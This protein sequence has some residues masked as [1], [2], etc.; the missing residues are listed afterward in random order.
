MDIVN[1]LVSWDCSIGGRN[2]LV[3]IFNVIKSALGIIRIVVPIALIVL[4]TLDVS[5]KVLNPED[6][7]AQKKIMI[8][9]I[10][11]LLVFLTPTLIDLTMDLLGGNTSSGLSACW[12]NA[13]SII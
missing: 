8:R 6:K 11:A 13:K 3:P 5:K 9:A 1:M 4:T 12:S 10:A 7:D 2:S